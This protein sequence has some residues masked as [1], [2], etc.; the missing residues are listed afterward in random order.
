MNLPTD[1]NV[2]A[3]LPGQERVV[4]LGAGFAGLKAARL[5]AASGEFQV[6]IIDRNNYHQFQ[7]L[8]YQVATAGLEPS[9]ISFPVRKTFQQKKNVFI[10]VA[11]VEK[12][13]PGNRTVITNKGSYKYHRLII[14]LGSST[15]YFGNS[16]LEANAIGLKSISEAL[17]I[18]NQV[19]KNYENALVTNSETDREAALNIVIAGGGPTGVELAGAIAELRNNVL[20]KEYP[21]L[22]FTK[23]NIFLIEAIDRLLNAMTA[24]S[25]RKAKKYLEKLGVIVQLNTRVESYDGRTVRTTAGEILSRNVVWTAGMKGVAVNGLPTDVIGPGERILVNEFNE[26]K[27]LKQVYVIG[28]LAVIP[29]AKFPKGHPQV[30]PV[31]IGQAKN[32]AENLIRDREGKPLKPFRYKDK[33]VMA[34]VGRNLAIVELPFLKFGGFPAWFTWMFVH[35]MSILGIKNR[36]F[37]FINW[38]SSY[39]SYNLSLRLIIKP[40]K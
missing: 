17:Y 2:P 29:T 40:G 19:L 11:E 9:S 13:D 16:Q 32:L 22:D 7:P 5:L 23:M 21:E 14:A 34:T 35:L 4:I 38:V 1:Q 12:I 24:S 25:S 6:L 18:R 15:N 37:I 27:G 39:L 8:L 10:R 28:D 30:A 3:P 31:A 36:F 26:V 33:G 20:P